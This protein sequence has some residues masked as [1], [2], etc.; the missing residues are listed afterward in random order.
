MRRFFLNRSRREQV[1][2]L[3]FALI[4]L[5]WWGSSLTARTKEQYRDWR[6]AKQEFETQELWIEQSEAIFARVAT[7]GQT[8]D[9]TRALDS[10]QTFAE[11]NR[12]L[13]GLNAEVG[14][15]RTE[16][17]D[18][19][20]LHNMQ[21]NI[22]RA[23]LADILNFYEKLSARAPYLGIDSCVIST[24]RSSRGMLNVNFR[25]YSIEVASSDG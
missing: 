18:Q 17:T 22:R 12:M 5:A 7:A 14:S 25:I 4:A 6:A 11:L 16:R 23:P 2:L 3:A 1:L 21:V 8:L 20:A 19:F 10:A 13:T 15:Q 24:D 9:P